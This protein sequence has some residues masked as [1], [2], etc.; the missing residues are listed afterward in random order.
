MPRLPKLAQKKHD[1]WH[2]IWTP[3]ISQ[4]G[5][6]F[7]QTIL[8]VGK[9]QYPSI[10]FELLF[11]MSFL[12]EF[13]PFC[14]FTSSISPKQHRLTPYPPFMWPWAKKNE[15]FCLHHKWLAQWVNSFWLEDLSE[16][17][18]ALETTATEKLK[19]LSDTSG[20][21]ATKV[22]RWMDERKGWFRLQD[23]K[24]DML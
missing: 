5:T 12:H 14:S 7:F 10:G 21:L 11:S 17:L 2:R 4:R 22:R 18:E 8:S 24:M 15:W 9:F 1:S 16:K 6:Y 23:V 20:A 13:V 3:Y 19:D